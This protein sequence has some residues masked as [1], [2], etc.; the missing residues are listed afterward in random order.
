MNRYFLS[1]LSV[2]V[3]CSPNVFAQGIEKVP[4][5]IAVS[6]TGKVSVRPD[7]AEISVGVSSLAPSAAAA[8]TANSAAMAAL[9][10][11]L[12]SNGIDSRDVTT[13]N[14]NVNPE[15]RQNNS[16]SDQN[17]PPQVVGY[18]VE[19]EVRIK[20]RN[21]NSLGPLLDATVRSGA[22]NVHSIAF[23][24]DQ[25]DPFVDKARVL[26]VADAKRKAEI[27]AQASGI[28]LGRVLYLSEAGLAPQPPQPRMMMS[29]MG[30]GSVPVAIGENDVEASITV[31]YAIE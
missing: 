15:Y 2:L 12:K 7:T 27:Y 8:L 4:P 31:V 3:L 9:L 10:A 5:S 25:P 16:V 28:K 17:R 30:G 26:A 20:V 24:I 29:A 6:G 22:N 23:S 19:N 1:A 14:F 13:S 11:T 18:R 21:I